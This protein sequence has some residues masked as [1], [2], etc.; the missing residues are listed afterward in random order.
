M[1]AKQMLWVVAVVAVG[2]V[3]WAGAAQAALVCQ[4]GILDLTA[5][6]GINPATGASWALGDA[7]RFTFTSS[8]KTQGTYSDINYYNTFVQTLANA[9]PLNIGAT[10]GV[11]W[12]AIASTLAIAARDNT[13]TNGAVNGT[14]ESFWLLD[15]STLVADNYADLWG[16]ASHSSPINRTETGELRLTVPNPPWSN[17][18]WVW[19]GSNGDGSQYS[20]ATLGV[21]GGSRKGSFSNLGDA[22][23]INRDTQP[24]TGEKEWMLLYGLSE[25]LH[26]TP[27]PATMALLGL[28][29]LGVF[30]SRKRK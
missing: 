16:W 25:V 9:S 27:E 26:I 22:K 17:N 23:W 18:D 2:M 1:F 13:S 24:H 28:G 11:T 15:G 12:K 14:G 20:G 30:L 10:Q 5:N 29:G 7:Y 6:G 4:L 21:A 3:C 8:T 19:T